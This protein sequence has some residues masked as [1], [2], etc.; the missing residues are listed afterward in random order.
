MAL[1]ESVS[2]TSVSGTEV[3]ET[4]IERKL[5]DETRDFVE[6]PGRDRR[7]RPW[8]RWIDAELGLRE[9]WYPVARSVD[10]VEGTPK[11]VKVLGEE[12]LLIRKDGRLYGIEDRCAHRGTRFSERP[13]VLSEDTV[14]CWYHTWTFDLADGRVRCILNDPETV[15]KGKPGIRA[16]EVVE[17]KG[18]VFAFIGDGDAPP[19]EDDLPPGFSDPDV[20]FY[21]DERVINANWRL[22]LENAFDPGHHFI[23]NWSPFVVESGFPITFG[24]VAKKGEEHSQVQYYLEGPGPKGFTRCTQTSEFMFEATIPGRPGRPDTLYKAPGA[25]GR[26]NEELLEQFMSMRPI[27]IGI[28]LPCVN[29]I[30][31]FPDDLVGYE[32]LVAVDESTTVAFTIGGKRC[33]TESEADAWRGEQGYEEWKVPTI[34]KFIVDDDKARES[35]QK[36]YA[37]EDGWYRER[38]YRPDLEITMFRKFFAEHAREVQTKEHALGTVKPSRAPSGNGG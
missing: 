36:F 35:M 11:A 15:L 13:L 33:T 21:V 10:V 2:E 22:C 16:Y 8:Q 14:T 28:W 7:H 9:Y 30:E 6:R 5:A 32:W 37:E 27:T 18:L 20:V 4:G 3:S 19:L 34:D 26:T 17:A 31:N 29:S 24:Y 12:L 38:L 25:V 1:T 23:H